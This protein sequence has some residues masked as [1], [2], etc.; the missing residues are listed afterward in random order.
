MKRF[1]LICLFLVIVTLAVK[2]DDIAECVAKQYNSIME[3]MQDDMDNKLD[4]LMEVR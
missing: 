2:A 3:E 4:S 1:G